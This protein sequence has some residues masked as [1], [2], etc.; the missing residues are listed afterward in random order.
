MQDI[1]HQISLSHKKAAKRREKHN[2]TAHYPSNGSAAARISA[3]SSGRLRSRGRRGS[4]GRAVDSAMTAC[5][6]AGV[7][8][9]KRPMPS[10]SAGAPAGPAAG[11]HSRLPGAGA[12]PRLRP[13]ECARTGH[14]EGRAPPAGA[15]GYR[16]PLW[17]S[18]AE[19]QRPPKPSAFSEK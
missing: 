2:K 7:Y 15:T 13:A 9:R 11:H 17:R 18:P 1:L 8:Q 5:S 4:S 12:A 16:R 14:G 19:R 6:W 3:A 10:C